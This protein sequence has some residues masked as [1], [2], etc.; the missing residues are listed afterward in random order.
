MTDS[1]ITTERPNSTSAA[2]LRVRLRWTAVMDFA[3]LRMTP[4]AAAAAAP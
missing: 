4:H 1:V 3:C 2:R